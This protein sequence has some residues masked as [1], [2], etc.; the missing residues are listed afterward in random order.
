MTMKPQKHEQGELTVP[1]D[2]LNNID[3]ISVGKQVLPAPDKQP[4]VTTVNP[5]GKHTASWDGETTRTYIFVPRV[6][7]IM[8]RAQKM[9]K[10]FRILLGSYCEKPR[11]DSCHIC[12]P[13]KVPDVVTIS[14]QR[15]T[16]NFLPWGTC[17]EMSGPTSI[18]L[19]AASSDQNR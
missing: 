10:G 16:F 15:R 17:G 7:P 4:V 18:P 6:W 9:R 12:T 8:L 2:D 3:H 11:G 19:P 1:R 5:L 14:V 13:A